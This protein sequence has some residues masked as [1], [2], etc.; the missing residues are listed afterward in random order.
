MSVELENTY[1]KM[2]EYNE[3]KDIYRRN[4]TQQIPFRQ[5]TLGTKT[6]SHLKMIQNTLSGILGIEDFDNAKLKMGSMNKD[7]Y[8]EN[9]IGEMVKEAEEL[10]DIFDGLET[11]VDGLRQNVKN[12]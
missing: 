8:V 3:T 6:I 5:K 7:Q 1:R 11:E 10:A 9:I 4:E 12:K 2:E